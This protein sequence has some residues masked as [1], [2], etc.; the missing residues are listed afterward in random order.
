MSFSLKRLGGGL[1]SPVF[2]VAMLPIFANMIGLLG[3]FNID[4]AIQAIGLVKNLRPGWLSGSA[5]VIDPSVAYLLQ[6]IGQLAA[7]DWLHFIVPWWNPYSG[8]GMPLAAETQTEA[9]FLP[10]VLLLHFNSGWLLLR[11][12]LQ[13][14]CGVFGYLLFKEIGLTKR[15]AFLG[16]ALFSFCPE[17][18]LCPSAPIAPLP[19]LPLLLLGIEKSAKAA[20]FGEK[21]GWP[22]IAVACA[23]SVYAGNLEVAFF[24]GMLAACWSLWRMNGLPKTAKWPFAT[25]LALGLAV[26]IGLSLPL[27][28]PAVD[29]FRL[30]YIQNHGAGLQY[31]KLAPAQ[32][33]LQIMPYLYGRF[34]NPAPAASLADSLSGYERMPG[35][36]G[37]PV[38]ALALSALVRRGRFSLLKYILLGWIVIWETRYVGFAPTIYF[39]N[40]IPGVAATDAARYSGPA[41]EFALYT[42]A[43]FGLDDLIRCPP[44]KARHIWFIILILFMLAGL[45][46]FPVTSFIK[47]WYQLKPLDMYVGLGSLLTA[48]ISI[49]I[50]CYELRCRRHPRALIVTLLA[51]PVFTF[52]IPQFAGLRAGHTD[53]APIAFLKAHESTS[54]IIS[55]GPLGVDFPTGYNI[56]SINHFALPV[57]RLWTDYIASTLFPGA[58]LVYYS[59]G[60]NQEAALLAHSPAYQSIGV[61]YA[62]AFPNDNYFWATQHHLIDQRTIYTTH[63]LSSDNPDLTGIIPAP[64]T[65]PSIGAMSVSLGTYGRATGPLE[66][67][68]C[69]AGKCVT[70]TADTATAID[71]APFILNFRTALIVPPG[72]DVSYRFSHVTGSKLAIWMGRTA[73]GAEAPAINLIA[74]TAG[75]VPSLVFQ[76]PSAL[77]FELPNP[78][79]YVE[80]RDTECTVSVTNRER[81]GTICPEATTLIRRELFY[82]G[83][84]A[85]IN[86][87]AVQ[88]SQSGLFQSVPVPAGKAEIK[89]FYSPPHIK[90]A[91]ILA[92]LSLATLLCFA[93]NA[94]LKIRLQA[95]QCTDP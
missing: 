23:Y 93:L 14:L 13:S 45:A 56:A 8:I 11:T 34:D 62:I 17:F 1:R 33:P 70:V 41:V 80:T 63:N 36:V 4:P 69:A 9:F 89:F 26:A 27:L 7:N 6:P 65:L 24:D 73:D 76:D 31:V 82:P 91:C 95:K 51:G 48:F 2:A 15:A 21:C 59:A 79:P 37:L 71:D 49:A 46:I 64:L 78:A 90:L 30:G 39:L 83:W 72:N 84:A 94:K 68:L 54:R 3:I 92:L 29:L 85:R 5:G 35:W 25:R 50:L 52:V 74:P 28:W 87:H 43:A 19:F 86:G 16:A 75:P 12:V 18:I 44:V 20:A 53:M 32:W 60:A 22:L 38:L 47:S 81:I 55:L 77:I 40:S 10:F 66:A 57:P 88:V 67:T 61:R 58:D 42:L